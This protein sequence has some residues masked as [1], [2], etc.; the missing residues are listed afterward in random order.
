MDDTDRTKAQIADVLDRITSNDEAGS[1]FRHSAGEA[2]DILTEHR[3]SS[4]GSS[5]VSANH[6]DLDSS[7]RDN[8]MDLDSIDNMSGQIAKISISHD[9]DYATAVCLAAEEPMEGDV[10]G[11]AGA[12]EPL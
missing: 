2:V 8:L 3:T 1:I 12:R 5:G 11:E 9:G 4:R 6:D 7:D 10:G